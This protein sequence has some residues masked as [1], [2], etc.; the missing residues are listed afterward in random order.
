MKTLEEVRRT[1]VGLL[2]EA[3][4]GLLDPEGQAFA[5]A[6]QQRRANEVACPGHERVET[7]S[8]EEANRG[9]HR[10]QCKH[11]GKDMTYDSGD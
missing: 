3:E 8:R 5:R 11:C 6:Y 1:P 9:W 2:S 10:G 4:I 7:A